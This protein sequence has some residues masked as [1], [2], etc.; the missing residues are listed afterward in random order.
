MNKKASLLLAF[1]IYLRFIFMVNPPTIAPHPIAANPLNSCP[2]F[3]V[4]IK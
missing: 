2:L 1:S 4:F 3:E